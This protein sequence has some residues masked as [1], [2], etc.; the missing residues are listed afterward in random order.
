MKSVSV[1]EGIIKSGIQEPGTECRGCREGGKC[2]LRFLENTLRISGNVI[3]LTF[4]GMV[5]KISRD[6]WENYGEFSCRFQGMFKWITRD[7]N[8]DVFAC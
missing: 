1:F 4:R 2:S 7:V 6:V 8:F 3:I 5:E